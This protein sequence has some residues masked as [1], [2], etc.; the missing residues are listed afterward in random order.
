MKC[1]SRQ[2]RKEQVQ[3]EAVAILMTCFCYV[4]HKRYHYKISTLQSIIDEVGAMILNADKN[5]DWAK[6]LQ[7]WR[8]KVGLK[9]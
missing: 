9:I 7:F 2:R 5:T 6:G 8:D 3:T 1:L 4:L